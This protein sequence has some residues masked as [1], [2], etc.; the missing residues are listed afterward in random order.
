[1][2]QPR[3]LVSDIDGTLVR[4]D[5]SLSDAVVAAA[6]RLIA[7]GTQMSLI[8]ARPP[9]GM[10]W[11]A[12][13][14]GLGLAMGAFNGGTIVT[15]DGTIV[16]A[17]RLA[18]E[19]A[20]HA[21][22]LIDRPDVIVWVFRAGRWHAQRV[23]GEHD[24]SERKAANQEPVYGGDLTA[25]TDAADKIVAVSDDHAML[26]DLEHAVAEALGRE[27]TV[28]R[29]QAYYLDITAPAANKGDGIAALAST[30]G[31]P[32]AQTVAIGDQRNDLAMFERVGLSI[33]MGQG[34]E[35]VRAAADKVTRANEDDGVARAIDDILLPMLR[36]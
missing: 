8:S 30:I 25:L 10:L 7:A 13:T 34:P 35:D 32:L 29:S 3:L 36:R 33:A 22:A 20:R 21:L 26:A 15:P 31:V 4:H 27:A 6:G 5:K 2:N 23:A 12:R 16:S 14:L 11:I 28:V 1:M 17:E 24:R 9:S 19:V 18:P